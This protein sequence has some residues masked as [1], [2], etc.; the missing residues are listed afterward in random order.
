MD[1][2]KFSFIILSRPMTILII[3]FLWLT[4]PEKVSVWTD[5]IDTANGYKDIYE[6]GYPDEPN[7]FE[8]VFGDDYF[9]IGYAVFNSITSL[10]LILLFYVCKR[11]YKP[12]EAFDL[13][14][15]LV[16]MMI[17]SG[18]FLYNPINPFIKFLP[19]NLRYPINIAFIIFLAIWLVFV[20]EAR[21]SLRRIVIDLEPK[22]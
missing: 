6:V 17:F 2:N 20:R 4:L 19:P 14:F 9:V 11:V 3:V 22:P 13:Q 5:S 18:L 7:N 15:D 8:E 1:F 10:F 12:I 16:G 21:K